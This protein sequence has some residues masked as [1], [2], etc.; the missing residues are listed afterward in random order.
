KRA[1]ANLL[2]HP[3]NKTIQQLDSLKEQQPFE[4]IPRVSATVDIQPHKVKAANV[5]G[6][7]EGNDPKLKD[8][9]IVLGAHYDHLGMGGFFTGSLQPDTFAIHNGADDNASG[10]AAIMTV[11]AQLAKDHQL[12]KR[13]VII[14]RLVP[15]KKAFLGLNILQNIH[16]FR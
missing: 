11:A 4:L 12:L 1:V 16:P 7:I 10:S 5:I 15:K 2:L 8:E 9:Y 3:Q 6:Y 13:S 14:L